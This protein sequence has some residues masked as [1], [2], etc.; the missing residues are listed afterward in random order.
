MFLNFDQQN[1]TGS[2]QS[3]FSRTSLLLQVNVE[4]PDANTTSVV[5]YVTYLFHVGPHGMQ[6]AT[7]S[8]HFSA[9]SGFW[10]LMS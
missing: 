1:S 4:H 8:Q 10:V 2:G 3:T 5:I 6:P 9:A 7:H